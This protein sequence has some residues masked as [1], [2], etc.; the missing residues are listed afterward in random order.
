MLKKTLF[1]LLILFSAS[2]FAAPSGVDMV[3]S[4]ITTSISH[5]SQYKKQHGE[6]KPVPT[7]VLYRIIEQQLLPHMDA[8]YMLR[9][10][11]ARQCQYQTG[12][13]CQLIDVNK[14]P[15]SQWK[16]LRNQTVMMMVN[17]YA[18]ALG[19]A[20]DYKI[21]FRKNRVPVA[22][23]P[24]ATQQVMSQVVLPGTAP[25]IIDYQLM[26][27]NGQWLVTDFSINGAIS[28]VQNLRAQFAPTLQQS[29]VTGLIALL[30]KHNAGK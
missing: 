28:V 21:R 15:A 11:L 8:D 14:I 30:K 18:S 5:L 23:N 10:I 1:F 26:F 17:L 19:S 16:L 29:G 13:G 25:V 3:R 22:A 7:A 6:G 12:K 24:G 20:D 27:K 2:A 4:V 9:S